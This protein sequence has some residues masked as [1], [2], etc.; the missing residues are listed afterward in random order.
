MDYF[1]QS[2]PI[3]SCLR[4]VDLNPW[5]QS[6]SEGPRGGPARSGYVACC[7]RRC[8]LCAS[9]WTAFHPLPL[10]VTPLSLLCAMTMSMKL[11][12]GL[13]FFSNL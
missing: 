7:E 5:P 8:V 2:I 9:L 12:L 13:C 10:M 6:L 4:E 3:V 1:L 11:F